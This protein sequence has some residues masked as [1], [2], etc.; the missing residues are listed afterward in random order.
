MRRR[1]HRHH[2]R[3][4]K[5]G[6]A[7]AVAAIAF[8]GVPAWADGKAELEAVM[9]E[10]LKLW[11]AHDAASI[12]ERFYRLEGNSP[13]GT[14]EGLTAEF[15]R[16]KAQGYDRSD[17]QSVTGC[18]LTPDTGQVELR[19]VRLRTDGSFMPPKD[20][21]SI[22]SLRKFPD[23]WRVTGMRGMPADQKM[24]CPAAPAN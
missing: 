5:R 19:Y 21:A 20:R 24:D 15:D 8:C 14:T 11:N 18:L 16:L 22:Y 4:V 17:I 13:W 23:G 6:L 10:Y 12:T 7:V 2:L 3:L 9:H 1:I